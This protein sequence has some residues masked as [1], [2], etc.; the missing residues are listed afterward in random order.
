MS[1]QAAGFYGGFFYAVIT[2]YMLCNTLGILSSTYYHHALRSPIKKWNKLKDDELRPLIKEIFV[3]SQKRFGTQKIKLILKQQGKNVSR[4]HIS[5][6]MQEMWLICKQLK[7]RYYS[8]TNR[9]YKVYRKRI[10]QNFMPETPNMVW[11]SDIPHVHVKDK[12]HS[13]GVIIDLYA[14]MVIEHKVSATADVAFIQ[15]MFDAA[16]ETRGRHEG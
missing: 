6:L 11:G 7:F 13:I 15:G 3:N 5:R 16:F 9:K 2:A 10:Q 12:L 4:A 14:R 8:T 1:R